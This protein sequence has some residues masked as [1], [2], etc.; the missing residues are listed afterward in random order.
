M[1]KLQEKKQQKRQALLDAAY[2][3]FLEQGMN[4]TSIDSIVSRA[5]VA[6]GTFYLYFADK[7]AILQALMWRI[8]EK[9][10]DEALAHADRQ[11]SL[12]FGDKV[13]DMADYII[14][15]FRR[16]ILLLS[17]IRHNLRWP[18]VCQLEKEDEPSALLSKV[19]QIIRSCHEMDGKS[20]QEIYQWLT[21]IVSMC[22]SV[23]YGCIIENRP[24]TID[25]MKPV[26]YSIIKK[27]LYS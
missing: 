23:S 8:S 5:K 4:K 17:L 20:E 6:K 26:L 22:V 16:N 10:F 7:D 27:S 1:G 11:G 15:Y 14:E 13:V 24:D 3:L 18:R 2:D 21:A 9:I 12:L 19:F 25:N